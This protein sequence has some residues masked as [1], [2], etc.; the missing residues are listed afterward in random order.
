MATSAQPQAISRYVRSQAPEARIEVD[1][2]EPASFRIPRTVYG[3]FLEDIGHSVFGGVSA[4]LLDNPSL[5]TYHAALRVL[6]ERFPSQDFDRSTWIGLPLPW[7]PLRWE[8][9]VRYEPRWGHAA[10]SDQ[11]LYL[12]GSRGAKWASAKLSTCRTG[13]N[14]APTS[15]IV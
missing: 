1:A 13:T 14:F 12:M 5:E 11:Y 9:G 3:T 4:Q 8:D 7:R 2:G 10:N 15:T 6:R